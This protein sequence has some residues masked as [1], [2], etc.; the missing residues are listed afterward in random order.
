MCCRIVHFINETAGHQNS[1]Q[2][3]KYAVPSESAELA[4]RLNTYMIYH[5]KSLVLLTGSSSHRLINGNNI[6]ITDLINTCFHRLWEHM[7]TSMAIESS[8]LFEALYE[9]SN[10]I[11]LNEFRCNYYL[12]LNVS[13]GH[14]R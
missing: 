8:S 3:L 5:N 4:T 2:L 10:H 11:I 1:L 7:F 6:M 9:F 12:I 14:S 13:M